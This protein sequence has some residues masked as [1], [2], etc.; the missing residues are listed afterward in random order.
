MYKTV[1]D[2]NKLK[3]TEEQVQKISN[4]AKELQMILS[5]NGFNQIEA[6]LL[7]TVIS[8]HFETP[9]LEF[10]CELLNKKLSE[11]I[12]PEII[13]ELNEQIHPT[14]LN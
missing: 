1:S 4:F 3:L 7:F 10:I 12:S 11:R 6:G 8:E 14:S 13:E 2:P 5:Q 9:V